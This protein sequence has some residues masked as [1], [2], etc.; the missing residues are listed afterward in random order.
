MLFTDIL[1]KCGGQVRVV[2]Y[3]NGDRKDTKGAAE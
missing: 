2:G 3:V 1:A